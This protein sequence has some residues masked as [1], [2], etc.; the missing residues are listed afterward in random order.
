MLLLIQIITLA[1]LLVIFLQDISS[2][3]VYWILFP[4]LT[5]LFIGI[6]LISQTLNWDAGQSLII[7]LGFLSLQFLLVSAWFSFKSGKWINITAQ[8]LGWGDVLFLVS[9]AFYLSVLNFLFF[10]MISLVGVLVVWLIWQSIAGKTQK[11]IPLAGFQ[12]I[13]FMMFLANGWWLANYDMTHDDWLL[14][15]ITK[16]I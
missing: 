11:H 10:Y 14:Q 12:A 16:W 7:N 3:S 4:L 9:I 13:L 6:R 5:G 2:R 1:V 8:L 15:L